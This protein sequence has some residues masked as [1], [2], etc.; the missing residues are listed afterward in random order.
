MA[1]PFEYAIRKDVRNNPIVREIDEARQRELWK[2]VGVAA[3]LVLMLLFW[4]WQ[5]FELLRHGYR[6]EELQRQR[7][8]EEEV[9]RHLRLEIET[10]RSPQRIEALAT[11]RLHL[12]TPSREEAIVLER[13]V[14]AEPPAAS[15][16]ARRD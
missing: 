9:A 1:E 4:A 11:G 16:V 6:V 5:Q 2:S 7:A 15:V 8:A 13:V 3:F 12:V 14:P 10:L